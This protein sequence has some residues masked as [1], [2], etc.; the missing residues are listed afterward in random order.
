MQFNIQTQPT[1]GS[2]VKNANGSYSYTLA[3]NFNDS[4]N[5]TYTVTDGEWVSNAATVRINIAAVNDAPTLGDQA[6]KKV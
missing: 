5:F 2:L 6:L 3:A 4:D 1:H